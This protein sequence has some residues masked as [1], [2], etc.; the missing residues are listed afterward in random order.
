M[1]EASILSEI[2]HAISNRS[3]WGHIQLLEDQRIHIAVMS[4]PYLTFVFSTK[5]TIES[6][7]TLNRITPYNNARVGDI[8]FLK[9]GPIVGYFIVGSVKFLELAEYPVDLIH[10]EYGYQICANDE[11]WK[12]QESKK[13]ATLLGVFDVHNL[14]PLTIQKRDRRAW[15]TL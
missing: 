15:V 1:I 7:F 8:V 5:K 11:F 6:R 14:S 10:K 4:E 3:D 12:Q 2:K 9:H 13:Y